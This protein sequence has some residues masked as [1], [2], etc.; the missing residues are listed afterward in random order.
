M[1]VS[2]NLHQNKP[3]RYAAAAGVLA[4]L[5]ALA[6]RVGWLDERLRAV[7]SDVSIPLM[8][9]IVAAAMGWAARRS[10]PHN[11]QLARAWR[12]M[13]LSQGL[14][15]AGNVT[16][17]LL[18]LSLRQPAFPSAADAFFLLY[19][20]LFAVGLLSLPMQRPSRWERL[21]LMLEIGVVM[22]SAGLVFWDLWI[23]PLVLG[24]APDA[25][26]LALAIAYPLSDLIIL[27]VLLVV[28]MRQVVSQPR[29][30]L[31]FLVFSSLLLITSNL[32]AGYESVTGEYA[33]R[34]LVE[35]GFVAS[36]I[37]AALAGVLQATA[38]PD[39]SAPVP[40]PSSHAAFILRAALPYLGVCAA[41]VLLVAHR[42]PWHELPQGFT[43]TAVGVSGVVALV[44]ARQIIVLM[45]NAQLAR[46]LQAELAERRRAQEALQ[47][48]NAELEQRVHERTHE[49][50]RLNQQ[51]RQSEDRLMRDAT[52]D[53]LTGLPNRP[54]FMDRLDRAVER[55][56]RH[57]DYVFAVLFL[58][59]DGFKVIN[60]SLGH[61]AGDL[62]LTE[63]ARRLQRC[64]RTAD[65][66]GR[67]GGDE[68]VI[69]LEDIGGEADAASAAE[70]IQAEL[71]QPFSLEGHRVF[72]SASIGIVLSNVGY[73]HPV[74]ILR[75]AD[76]AMYR[77]K[78]LGKARHVIFDARMRARAV[79]R[80]QMESELRNALERHEFQLEY[81]PIV[82]LHANRI[83][84]VEALLRWY[85]PQRGLVAPADF[86]PIAE[87]TGLIVPLGNWVLREACRQ[88]RDWHVYYPMQP[89]LTV[90][91]N[92]SARQFKQ[93]DLAEQVAR[94]LSETGLPV[95]C[96][97]LEITESTIM[98]DAETA[99]I[100]LAQLRALG[101]QLQIDD[102]GTGYSSLSYLH[103]FPINTLK[104]DRAFISR[105]SAEG[106]NAPIARTIVSLAHELGMNTIA[107]GVETD[108]QLAHV[109][110]LGCE[111]VQG[112]LISR[113][114]NR[115][116]LT[117]FIAEQWQR[118]GTSSGPVVQ[119]PHASNSLEE[120]LQ[121]LN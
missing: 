52:H 56:K 46:E 2:L 93:A 72:T 60:D 90:S 119:R 79:E 33:S 65:T 92:L 106:D 53:A 44:I 115:H 61:A 37:L 1:R 21:K 88:M 96:L 75:D 114:L 4:L 95:Q 28:T 68:F 31:L 110:L 24:G 30:P 73:S 70:R 78:S 67:L 15:F 7:A 97:K 57:G 108:Y 48:L 111:Q 91:V 18:E 109:R 98:D 121:P 32:V 81:Q 76:I 120:G 116:A 105:I 113:P 55:A 26:S 17:G 41:L 103:R 66:I 49:L 34:G 63:I 45:E 35:V 101:I 54:L 42:D 83:T 62:F 59:F 39:A 102:F 107:E 10:A 69:L 51:L 6:L 58:D 12:I 29:E 40:P 71:A 20:V 16:A 89:P 23:G 80:L 99:S 118:Q 5:L 36:F 86:I 112:Y 100:T 9:L 82:M 104:I 8:N 13:A 14:W 27:W 43:M 50:Q 19:Y 84:G 38:R 77:A 94:I 11:L 47:R 3:F 74:D 64:V 87:E 22:L 85:H 117:E 25:L